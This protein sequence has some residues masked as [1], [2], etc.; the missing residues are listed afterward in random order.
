L[1]GTFNPL[2]PLSGVR[3]LGQNA[4]NILE[5][6]SNGRS[7]NDSVSVSLNGTVKKKFNFWASY[8]WN[9]SRS[10]DNGTSGSANDAYDFS[11]EWG[12]SNYDNRHFFY[13]SGDYRTASGFS[14]NTF[15]IANSGNPFNITTGIDSNGDTLFTERP[16]FAGG[17]NS[18][19]V[20]VTRLGAFVL[21]PSPGERIIPRNFGNGP[22]GYTI[23]MRLAKTFTFR[24]ITGRAPKPAQQK[25]GGA[26]TSPA[27]SDRLYKLNIS[28]FA[29]NLLNRTNR[30]APIGNLSS[31]FF[32]LSNTLAS[33]A[34][35]LPG[36]S[37]A[38]SNRR[39]DIGLQWSF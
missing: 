24:G 33:S 38:A 19:A 36:S 5:Y 3:P 14:V 21:N 20:K 8:S 35:G 13:A 7:A 31:P 30:G 39:I 22:L 26:R 27:A 6:Q 37:N 29:F 25:S 16:A 4:G 9:K 28:V 15:V 18:T 32:G 34:L 23:N 10:T 12:R 2:L 1:A 17:Q 11:G